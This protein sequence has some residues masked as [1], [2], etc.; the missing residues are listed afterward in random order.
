[1]QCQR[2]PWERDDGSLVN[3]LAVSCRFMFIRTVKLAD[4]VFFLKQSDTLDLGA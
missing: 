4:Y 3:F 2:G 1:M